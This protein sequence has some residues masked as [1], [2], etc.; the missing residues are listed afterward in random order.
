M[1]RLDGGGTGGHGAGGLR[2]QPRRFLFA[3][4]GRDQDSRSRARVHGKESYEVGR[5]PSCVADRTH[6]G[7]ELMG[8]KGLDEVEAER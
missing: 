1:N 4:V 7:N 6:R 8:V 2:T 5:V 3:G